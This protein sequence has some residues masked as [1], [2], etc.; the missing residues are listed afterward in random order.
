[1]VGGVTCGIFPFHTGKCTCGTVSVTGWSQVVAAVAVCGAPCA[2]CCFVCS[3]QLHLANCLAE[4]QRARVAADQ[5][6]YGR[7]AGESSPACW[8]GQQACG[9][10]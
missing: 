2:G 8:R 7:K 5:P 10:P 6:D 4:W 1:M 9:N 3:H